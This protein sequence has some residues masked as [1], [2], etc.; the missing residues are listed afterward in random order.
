MLKKERNIMYENLLFNQLKTL[1]KKDPAMK[2]AVENIEQDWYSQENNH[3]NINQEV[4]TSICKSCSQRRIRI[5]K[6]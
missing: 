1:M 5:C 3:G 2:N 6:R 4:Q